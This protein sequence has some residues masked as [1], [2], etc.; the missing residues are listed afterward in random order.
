MGI[1]SHPFL[2]CQLFHTS[3][4]LTFEVENKQK[5]KKSNKKQSLQLNILHFLSS[6]CQKLNEIEACIS[7]SP[8]LIFVRTDIRISIAAQSKLQK[9]SDFLGSFYFEL[10]DYQ[11]PAQTSQ[12]LRIPKEDH[13]KVHRA[14]LSQ[15]ILANF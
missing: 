1:N 14:Q 3:E 6:G 4:N 9:N 15:D 10:S 5:K 2:H 11:S 12:I 13:R 7:Q 8:S